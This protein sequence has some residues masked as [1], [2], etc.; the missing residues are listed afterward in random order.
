MCEGG[1]VGEGGKEGGRGGGREKERKRERNR[2]Y[3]KQ[4]SVSGNSDK[5]SR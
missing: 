5:I 3:K 4:I 1:R 2:Y